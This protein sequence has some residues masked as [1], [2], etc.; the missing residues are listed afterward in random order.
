MLVASVLKHFSAF[1]AKIARSFASWLWD[2]LFVYFAQRSF[3]S[4]LYNSVVEDKNQWCHHA[5]L[6]DFASQIEQ[7]VEMKKYRSNLN[8]RE[9]NLIDDNFVERLV[10]DIDDETCSIEHLMF[11]SKIWKSR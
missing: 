5:K 8:D 4:A 11:S 10:D 7:I 2:V 3:E 6:V 1:E 9:V